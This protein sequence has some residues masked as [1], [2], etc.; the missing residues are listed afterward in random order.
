LSISRTDVCAS[1]NQRSR[2]VSVTEI[3]S[4]PQSGLS[5]AG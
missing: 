5:P 2:D 1:F 3:C 4:G